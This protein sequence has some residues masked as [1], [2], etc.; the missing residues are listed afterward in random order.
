M[1]LSNYCPYMDYSHVSTSGPLADSYMSAC[2]VKSTAIDWIEY[3]NQW[4]P[5]DS[6]SFT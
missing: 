1:C 4:Q 3:V 5:M 6:C 2:Q